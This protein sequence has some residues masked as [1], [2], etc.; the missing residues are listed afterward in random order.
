MNLLNALVYS[1]LDGYLSDDSVRLI[2][3]L[4]GDIRDLMVIVLFEEV[5]V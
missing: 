2:N 3:C 1:L 4:I 5:K